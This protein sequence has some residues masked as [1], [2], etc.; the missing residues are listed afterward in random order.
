MIPSLSPAH[1]PFPT[2]H[3]LLVQIQTILEEECYNFA[4]KAMPEVLE[5]YQW[6][7]PE[8]VELNQWVS[9]LLQHRDGLEAPK[10]Y[11][12]K[13]LIELITSIIQVRHTAVHRLRI[14]AESFSYIVDDAE[15]FVSMLN[16]STGLESLAN[17]RREI[18]SALQKIER[19]KHLL[20][21]ELNET[22]EDIAVQRDILL[23]REKDAMAEMVEVDG[24]YQAMIGTELEIGIMASSAVSL[25]V[26]PPVITID[27]CSSGV[28]DQE[29][30]RSGDELSGDEYLM[31]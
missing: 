7:C 31:I 13:P 29:D 8:A 15:A 17:M 16:G 30:E 3:R 5:Q 23:R 2:Q 20:E 11:T 24:L 9:H 21:L 14:S 12:R 22:L 18:K 27:T 6:N 28:V 10:D 1:L 25:A 26:S 19:N 4:K